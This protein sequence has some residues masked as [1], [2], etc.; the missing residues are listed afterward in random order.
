MNSDYEVTSMETQDVRFMVT[1]L[2]AMGVF[3]AAVFAH[4][5]QAH[6]PTLEIRRSGD[7]HQHHGQP[8]SGSGLR[9]DDQA[10]PQLLNLGLY[11]FPVTTRSKLAQQFMNQGLN[12]SYAFNHAR[13]GASI[14][15]SG[16]TGPSLAM[17]Y[18]GQALV[19]GP[20]INAPMEP[21]DGM[22]A[23][24]LVRKAASLGEKASRASARLLRALEKR[25]SGNAE[26]RKANDKAYADAMRE[27]HRRFPAD[28]DIAMLYVESVMDLNSWGYWMRDG[29]P[30]EGTAEIVAITEEVM[31][32]HPRHP[33]AP[34]MYIHL[35]DRA[36]CDP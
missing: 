7:A 4:A 31:R 19:L 34:H 35:I 21:K 36:D 26:R 27:V 32:G 2:A 29:Y 24:E 28:P 16:K 9:Q 22:P 33:G 23:L 5:V 10:P 30:M 18:W 14:L 12:L 6:E 13:G 1:R 11:A 20:N 8:N 25:Y 17:A 3:I 15:G